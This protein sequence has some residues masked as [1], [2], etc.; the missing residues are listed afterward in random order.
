[1]LWKGA[2]LIKIFFEVQSFW[3]VLILP[4]LGVLFSA[5]FEC[6]HFVLILKACLWPQ[7]GWL[8]E[9]QHETHCREDSPKQSIF[10]R[11]PCLEFRNPENWRIID[12]S[13][14]E[15]TNY[16]WLSCFGKWS[17]MTENAWK[18]WH[19]KNGRNQFWLNFGSISWFWLKFG[20][21]LAQIQ[22]NFGSI[23]VQF[24]LNFS[25]YLAQF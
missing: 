11:S 22:F 18:R 21:I 16:Y 25:S 5:F 20:L 7:L 19:G 4:A 12:K 2:N 1:M 9:A 17:K 23:L 13:T 15:L 10:E 14:L 3:L 6:W 8:W 24:R